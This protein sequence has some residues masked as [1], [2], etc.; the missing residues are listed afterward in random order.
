MQ[1][2][3]WTLLFILLLQVSCWNAPLCFSYEL[4]STAWYSKFIDCKPLIFDSALFYKCQSCN[5][6]FTRLLSSSLPCFFL[7]RYL[8]KV[9]CLF[10]GCLRSIGIVISHLNVCYVITVYN[11][12]LIGFFIHTWFRLPMYNVVISFLSHLIIFNFRDVVWLS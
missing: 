9:I 11:Q 6:V 5:W 3:V 10:F 8:G 12:S 7:A 2:N 4:L 1:E